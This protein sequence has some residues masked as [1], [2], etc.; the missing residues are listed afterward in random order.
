MRRALCNGV[1][2][3]T[4]LT[5]AACASAGG[6]ANTG[7][8]RDVI[9]ADDVARVPQATNAYDVID[10]LRPFWLKQNGPRSL[11]NG[12][13][14]QVADVG[15]VGTVVF[16]D[17][18]KAGDLE[19]LKTINASAIKQIRFLDASEATALHGT[20]FLYGAIEVTTRAGR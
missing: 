11:A 20:G 3:V 17:G 9:T 12:G 10:R 6:P 15:S 19:Q 16:I 1:M 18:V 13:G 4:F 5:L 7:G 8:D 14:N 2:A